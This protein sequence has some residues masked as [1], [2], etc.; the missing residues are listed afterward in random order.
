MQTER[1]VEGEQRF[2]KRTPP[3]SSHGHTEADPSYLDV[4]LLQDLS[5]FNPGFY[6][7]R[8]LLSDFLQ[9]A[10]KRQETKRSISDNCRLNVPSL[11]LLGTVDHLGDVSF[12]LVVRRRVKRAENLHGLVVVRVRLQDLLEALRGVFFVSPIHVHLSQAE[13]RQH[14][15]GRGELGGL[16]VILEGLVVVLLRE[17]Q[18][19]FNDPARLYVSP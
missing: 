19:L 16:V 17:K 15:G 13:E 10:L 14:E 11:R 1:P 5:K 18:T 7:I 12:L 3:Q 9:V 6:V 2:K 8:I 4:C